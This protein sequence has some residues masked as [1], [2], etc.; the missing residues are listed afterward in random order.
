MNQQKLKTILKTMGISLTAILIVAGLITGFFFFKVKSFLQTPVSS[1]SDTSPR[2]IIF[3]IQPGQGLNPIAANLEKHGLISSQIEFKLYVRYKKA[4]TRLKAGEYLLSTSK[5]PIQILD[6]LVKG[7]VRV[8]KLTIPEGLNMDEIASLVAE[9]DFCPVTEFLSLCLDPGFIK[10]LKIDSHTLEGYLF[11]DTYF[12]PKHTPCRQIIK[13]MVNT[14]HNVY[15]R[16]WQNRTKALGF[17]IHE[18][19]TLASIIEKETGDASERPLISSV[20]HNRLKKRMRLE[21]DPTVIYGDKDFDG[22]IRRR[23]LKRKT[24]YNTY[25]IQG[26]PLGPI[27]NPGALA[28]QSALYPV[29]SEYLFFVSKNDT[30]HKFSKT[31]AEHNRAVKKYQLNR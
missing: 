10:K 15:T 21:S 11:P 4:G 7:K 28:I 26:L 14:F 2:E 22:R 5:T 12:F 30:T 25:Q 16:E 6:K 23:H 3:I 18:I 24:P 29:R 1:I 20:F 8:Y 13:K 31:F 19:V 9:A 27:A 17:S